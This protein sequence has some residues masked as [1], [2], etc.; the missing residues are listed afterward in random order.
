MHMIV[1]KVSSECLRE[2]ELFFYI[3]GRPG[4]VV[5][6]FVPMRGDLWFHGTIDLMYALILGLIY[7]GLTVPT[8]LAI[9]FN[10]TCHLEVIEVNLEFLP[11]LL[12]FPLL[13]RF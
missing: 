9:E 1:S 13:E 12:F 7:F 11:F 10:L 4:H 5:Q 2:R 8:C 6:I 3:H